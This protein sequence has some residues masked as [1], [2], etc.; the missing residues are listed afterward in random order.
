MQAISYLIIVFNPVTAIMLAWIVVRH[1]GAVGLGIITR[2]FVAAYAVGLMMQAVEHLEFLREW[3]EP[4]ATAW[5][6]RLI[7]QH[8]IAWSFFFAIA[9]NPIDGHGG[10]LSRRQ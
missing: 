5:A 1:R 7:A 10:A 8:G 9:W 2:A 4:R 6:F 3:R